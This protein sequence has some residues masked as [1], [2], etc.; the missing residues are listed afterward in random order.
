MKRAKTKNC[1]HSS[2]NVNMS[3]FCETRETL[4]HAHFNN[5]TDDEEFVFLFYLN[6]SKIPDIKYWKYHTFDVNS[7]CDDLVSQ[8]RFIKRDTPRLRDVLDLPNEIMCHF[9]NDLVVNSPE[10]LCIVLSRL[11]YP[12]RYVDMVPLFGRSVPQLIMIN[13]SK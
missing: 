3:N 7:Y 6:S 13:F 9:Y 12:C 5:V 2:S 1:K 11:A 8:F 4:L 10:A